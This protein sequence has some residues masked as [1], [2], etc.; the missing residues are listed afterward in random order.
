MVLGAKAIV[1]FTATGSTTLRVAR[2]RPGVPVLSM[3]PDL[4]KTRKLMLAYGVLVIPSQ[5]S[6]R[7]QDKVNS[8]VAL[9]RSLGIAGLGDTMV[10]TSGEGMP[11]STNVL[12]IVTVGEPVA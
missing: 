12:R 11:G 4:V 2:E 8:S 6:P 10:V 5:P 7:F 1:T 9:A 3:T